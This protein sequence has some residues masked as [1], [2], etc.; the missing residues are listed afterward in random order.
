MCKQHTYIIDYNRII[1]CSQSIVVTLIP[2]Y[3]FY[4]KSVAVINLD[5]SHINRNVYPIDSST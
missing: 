4:S 3:K 2:Y 1:K 5:T